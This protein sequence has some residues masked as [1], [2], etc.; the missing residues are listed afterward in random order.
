[1]QTDNTNPYIMAILKSL[2][3]PDLNVGAIPGSPTGYYCQCGNSWCNSGPRA[4]PSTTATALTVTMATVII[5]VLR[6]L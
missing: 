6:L 2:Y 1:M 4:R 5:A 3:F